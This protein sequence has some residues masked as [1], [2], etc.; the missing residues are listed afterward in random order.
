MNEPRPPSNYEILCLSSLKESAKT[1]FA[2]LGLANRLLWPLTSLPRWLHKPSEKGECW[3]VAKD[4]LGARAQ[5]RTQC[6]WSLGGG[7]SPA[8]ASLQ[9]EWGSNRCED[10]TMVCT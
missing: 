10:E 4:L 9:W 6:F 3:S 2:P 1:T 8:V 7:A 5:V